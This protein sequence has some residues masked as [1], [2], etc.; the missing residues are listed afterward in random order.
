MPSSTDFHN[1]NNNIIGLT[2]NQAVLQLPSNTPFP[3]RNNNAAIH[4][5]RRIDA[6]TK[7]NDLGRSGGCKTSPNEPM[8][9]LTT[10]ASALANLVNNKSLP[11]NNMPDADDGDAPGLFAG[12]DFEIPQRFTKSGRKKATPFPLKVSKRTISCIHKQ[13]RLDHIK[14]T[15]YDSS[16]I[17]HCCLFYST[18]YPPAV[19]F[20]CFFPLREQLMKVLSKKE[21]NDVIAWTPD[22]KSFLIVKPKAFVAD[23][24]PNHFK[25]AKYSSFTRKLHRWGFQRHLRVRSCCRTDDVA[26]HSQT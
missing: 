26:T 13:L 6:T 25:Q 21:N 5:P 11:N 14:F 16:K 10:A 15:K 3:P 20:S 7:L 24:L 2:A 1:N 18:W 23:I 12:F 19:S 9:E 8:K 4:Q 17:S 22:G